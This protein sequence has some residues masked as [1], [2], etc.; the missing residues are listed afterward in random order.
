MIRYPLWFLEKTVALH[1]SLG[2]VPLCLGSPYVIDVSS[3]L[4][5]SLI[6]VVFV[7]ENRRVRTGMQ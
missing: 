5:C 3:L 7:S 4:L 1:D 6:V 2:L